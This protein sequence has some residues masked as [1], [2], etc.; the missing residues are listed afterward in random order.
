MQQGLYIR[1]V[2]TEQE[3]PQQPR[4]YELPSLWR[5]VHAVFRRVDAGIA[6]LYERIG[7]TDVRPRYSA[8]LMFLDDGPMTIRQLAYDCGV[9][10]SAMSQTVSAMKAAGLVASVSSADDARHRLVSLTDKGRGLVPLLRAEWAATEKALAQLE[11]ETSFP[12]SQ[13][14]EELHAALDQKPF[15]DRAAAVIELPGASKR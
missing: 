4:R 1:A 11:A 8:T 15:A 5:R 2:T 13:L 10:H 9:T 14:A 6:E 3:Q 12:L 7:V